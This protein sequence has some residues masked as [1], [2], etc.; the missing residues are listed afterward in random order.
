MK[1]ALPRSLDFDRRS[2]VLSEFQ[3]TLFYSEQEESPLAGGGD[4]RL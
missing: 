4:R 1:G 2:R 3:K